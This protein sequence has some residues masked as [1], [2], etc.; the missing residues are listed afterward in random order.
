MRFGDAIRGFELYL[1]AERNLSPHTRRAYLSDIRQFAGQLG[2]ATA[3]S[4]VTTGDVRAFLAYLHARRHP[5]TLGRKLAALRS[6][7]RLQVREGRCALDPTA[8][9]SAPRTPKRLPNPLPVDDCIA[10]VEG[11]RASV[12]STEEKDLRNRA[13]PGLP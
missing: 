11:E 1:R 4:N 12:G 7:Y 3:P 2:E 10:L 5:A 13:L 8:G 6:F 9:I